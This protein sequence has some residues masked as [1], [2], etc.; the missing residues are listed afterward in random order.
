MLTSILSW[1]LAVAPLIVLCAESTQEKNAGDASSCSFDQW[2]DFVK[3]RYAKN[4]EEFRTYDETSPEHVKAFYRLNHTYQTLDF[5]LKKKEEYLPLRRLQMG[6]WEAMDLLDTIVDESDPDLD[7]PQSYHCYQTAEAIRRD[8]HPRWFILTGFIHDL[9][10]ILTTYGE[11]QW[12][13]VGDTFPV[14]SPYSE[15][16]VFPQYFSENPDYYNPVY[17]HKL[18]LYHEGCGL[19]NVHM[20]W[21]HDEYMYQVV[22]NYLPEEAAYVIRYHSFYGAHREEAY[23]ELL[24]QKDREMMKWVQLF[25]HYDLYSKAPDPINMEDLKPY[26]KELV[27]EFFPD[28][29]AW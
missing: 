22:K 8:G 7:L 6:I 28:K 27:A 24:N 5:V 2:E 3:D 14:G 21:G 12:A 9:G 20:S 23:G 13:V 16:L 11:P 25:S 19:D 10:K 1:G 18:G 26:Y 17:Q 15:K 29:I 4:K